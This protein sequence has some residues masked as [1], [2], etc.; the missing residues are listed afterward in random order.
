MSN[1]LHLLLRDGEGTLADFAGYYLGN[2][3][4]AVNRF[5]GREGPVFHARYDAVRVLD[6]RAAV[7]YLEYLI[8]NPVRAGLVDRHEQWPGLLLYAG[9]TPK[10]EEFAWRE[11]LR[12]RGAGVATR[13]QDRRDKAR[14][15]F[16]QRASLDVFPLPFARSGDTPTLLG[17]R[18]LLA[19]DA[20][21]QTL[22]S[23]LSDTP[24]VF[25]G[26]QVPPEFVSASVA[27]CE[28]ARA[29]ERALRLSRPKPP[30]GAKRVLAQ[31]P[32]RIPLRCKH[33]PKPLVLCSRA[34]GG[35]WHAFRRATSAFRS[36]YRSASAAFRAGH[37]DARFPPFSLRPGGAPAS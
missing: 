1:H 34:M 6:P 12:G 35:L 30:L 3:A 15:D 8:T 18:S 7:D 9:K 23:T 13:A 20:A 25:P 4:R 16:E 33:S 24:L 14:G 22:V 10:R 26:T 32:F 5:R 11:Q 29:V 27:A 28:Q 37:H 31:D 2:L 17:G 21:T 36:W 19:L